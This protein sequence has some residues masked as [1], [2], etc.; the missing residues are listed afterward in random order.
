MLRIGP[1]A[2][3]TIEAFR[4]VHV[5][6]CARAQ[7]RHALQRER[8]ARCLQRAPAAGRLALDAYHLLLLGHVDFLSALSEPLDA[9]IG[10]RKGEVFLQKRVHFKSSRVKM[11]AHSGLRTKLLAEWAQIYLNQR[12]SPGQ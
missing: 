11:Q 6:Q 12:K 1:C 10:A 8:F 3:P 4:P 7:H 5:Q 2:A 9:I